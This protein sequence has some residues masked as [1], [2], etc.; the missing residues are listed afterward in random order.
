VGSFYE[1]TATVAYTDEL[2]GTVNINSGST[3]PAPKCD[4]G[5][6]ATGNWF[7]ISGV[8][9][10]TNNKIYH[11]ASGDSLTVSFSGVVGTGTVEAG[12]ICAD[13]TPAP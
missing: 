11:N 9:A 7:W 12:I 1:R 3:P 6:F 4:A 2:L 5:D 13:V 10:P 8:G